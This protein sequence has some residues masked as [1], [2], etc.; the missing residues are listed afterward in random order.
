LRAATPGSGPLALV[1]AAKTGERAALHWD[2]IS[3][4]LWMTS[5][6]RHSIRPIDVEAGGAVAVAGEVLLPLRAIAV[7][8]GRN[9]DG[10]SVVIASEN[11][12]VYRGLV[13]DAGWV[14]T[15]EEVPLSIRGE[16]VA[17]ASGNGDD[18]YVAAVDG[19]DWSIVR[20]R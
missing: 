3:E 18:T 9:G 7:A 14:A 8:F 1:L 11:G 17:V 15:L 4:R 5:L 20:V 16:R 19:D 2:P 10:L 12:G 13:D 6:D